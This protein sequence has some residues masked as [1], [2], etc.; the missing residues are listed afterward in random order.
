MNFLSPIW[1]E[2]VVKRYLVRRGSSNFGNSNENVP[3]PHPP[4]LIIISDSSLS[5]GRLYFVI[6]YCFNRKKSKEGQFLCRTVL[7]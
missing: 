1:G 4:H 3:A 2:G 7:G 5:I 6:I